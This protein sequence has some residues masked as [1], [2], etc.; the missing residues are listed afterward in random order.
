MKIYKMLN[1]KI[2]KKSQ[3]AQSGD[4]GGYFTGN[5]PETSAGLIGTQSVDASQLN[6][7]FSRT[8]ESLKMV[9]SFA[10]DA[11]LNIAF[12]YNFSKGGAYGVYIPAL[13]FEIKTKALKR[14]LESKGYRIEYNNDKLTAYPKEENKDPKQINAEIAEAWNRL[15]ESGGSAIG[16]NLS[17][18]I[19]V[20]TDNASKI[21]SS[22]SSTGTQIPPQVKS[23]LDNLLSVYHLAATIIHEASHSK[24]GD[25]GAAQAD[26]Q[27]FRLGVQ[28]QLN[29]KYKNELASSNLEEFYSP[30]SLSGE[31]VH[32]NSIRWYKSAQFAN[33]K[34]TSSDWR[35]GT[36]N[37]Q[38]SEG[39]SDWSMLVQRQKTGP[40]EGKLSRDFMFPL[41]KD[42]DT[43]KDSIEAQ[44][45][46]QT[47]NDYNNNIRI[48]MEEQLADFHNESAS[49]KTMEELLEDN[50][51]KPLILPI[52]K[53]SRIQEIV[54][55]ATVFGWYNN[56][57]ISDGSTIPGLGD[58]VMLWDDR[59]ECFSQ[60]DDWI[61]SQSRYNPE[62]DIKG[63]FYRWIEPRFKPSLWT[64]FSQELGNTSPAKRFAQHENNIDKEMLEIINVLNVIQRNI[65]E[66][67]ISATR[68][69][70]STDLLPFIKKFFNKKDGI[71]TKQYDM[72]Q[73]ANGENV[74]SVWIFRHGV[75]ISYIHQSEHYFQNKVEEGNVKEIS[76]QVENLLG[77]KKS[78][79][80]VINE[81]LDAAKTVCK[82]YGVN[83]LYIV[84][85]FAREKLME[86]DP[87][88]YE[89]DFMC[90]SFD[91][92]VK[93]GNLIAKE[94]GV[95]P[96]V[97]KK[98]AVLSF[99]YKG[100][101]IDFQ[102]NIDIEELDK[103]GNEKQM[104]FSNAMTKD[105]CNRDFTINMF[106]YNVCNDKVED[107]FGSKQDLESKI[108]KTY[109]EPSIIL[110]HNPTIIL[111]ALKLKLKY[112]FEIDVELQKEMI[113]N[114]PFLFDGRYP[115]SKLIYLRE[116]IKAE[117]K[118]E[119]IRLFEEFGLE[120][121]NN[122]KTKG[123][124][125]FQSNQGD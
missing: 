40:I 55:T 75:P 64:D 54:K 106:A 16:V 115:E 109:F 29:E 82:K 13:D 110:K 5:V 10:P 53:A 11:L 27:S 43:D 44:L 24:G 105:L 72:G 117:N 93:I 31:K 58:R 47:K 94:L 85:T 36:W 14:E 113:K 17:D 65:G 102:G 92:N 119:A 66:K 78:Y 101:K 48:V 8:N 35:S 46:K 77:T 34:P 100:I 9:N 70:V 118:D 86:E 114:A 2:S 112:G 69:I 63:F 33:H 98:Q 90:T 73:G 49:Y 87:D 116:S 56:L 111:R 25:E 37:T 123:I 80:N 28:G 107:P 45:R 38:K 51:P 30:L 59:D 19:N 84:G 15:K 89:L 23:I 97:N 71:E 120:R 104:G 26:E 99:I 1:N 12:I 122:L 108:I 60:E 125:E 3:N 76:G 42:I 41:E 91:K 103:L 22:L 79:L 96:K 81:I 7:A 124:E 83:D 67:L 39:I 61:A 57:S 18:I 68:I 88:V 20:S 74:M 21:I 50:R 32:A 121:I 52:K 95:N 4:F 62:Y 6:S